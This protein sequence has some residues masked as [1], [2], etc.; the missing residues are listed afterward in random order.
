MT[1][2]EYQLIEPGTLN[3]KGNPCPIPLISV[4]VDGEKAGVIFRE[5]EQ[6]DIWFLILVPGNIKIVLPADETLE[7]VKKAWETAWQIAKKEGL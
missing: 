6:N 5:P 4:W 1:E 2:I 7:D 3:A